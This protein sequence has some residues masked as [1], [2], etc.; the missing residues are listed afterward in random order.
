MIQLSPY[1]PE[2]DA[3]WHALTSTGARTIAV[4]AA[5]PGEGTSL[6][7]TALARRAGMSAPSEMGR[8]D[9]PG[10]GPSALLVDLDLSRPS[11]SRLLGLRPAPDAIVRMDAMGISVF[12]NASSASADAWRERTRLISQLSAWQR[13]YRYIVMDTAPM[14][15]GESDEI[16]GATAAAAAD[17]CV[18]VT[19]A[20]RTPANRIR[21]AR[22]NLQA[23]GANLVGTILN[24]RDNQSLRAELDRQTY[25]FNRFMPKAM[26]ALR[27]RISRSPLIGARV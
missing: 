11:V 20:G 14:L 9:R 10:A 24:D 4:V 22:D 18:M 2:V 13:D 1:H 21:E 19:L 15:T 7:A 6:V 27:L 26:A 3:I 16:T 23:A 8:D 12:G 5:V 17:V 25:R